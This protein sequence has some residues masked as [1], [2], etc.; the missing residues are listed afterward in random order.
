MNKFKKIS[1]MI[2]RPCN[3][4]Y[5]VPFMVKYYKDVVKAWSYYK[6]PMAILYQEGG[7]FAV[8]G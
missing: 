7:A 1:E 8:S 2:R 5:S 4:V 3:I 6:R